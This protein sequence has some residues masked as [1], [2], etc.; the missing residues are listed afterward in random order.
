MYEKKNY[1]FINNIDT[2]SDNSKYLFENKI[3]IVLFYKKREQMISDQ[4]TGC[5]SM[6]SIYSSMEDNFNAI[7]SEE[8]K[9]NNKIKETNNSPEKNEIIISK[10]NTNIVLDFK[11][12]KSGKEIYIVANNNKLFSK[13]IKDLEKK[14]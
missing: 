9:I 14:Y 11:F 1:E 5:E 6:S 2:S 4:V 8:V 12:S 7:K 13:I 3:P 10:G